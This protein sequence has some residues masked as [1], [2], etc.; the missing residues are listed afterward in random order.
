MAG[1]EVEVR[2]DCGTDVINFARR[3]ERVCRLLLELHVGQNARGRRSPKRLRTDPEPMTLFARTDLHVLVVDAQADRL[4]ATR[5]ALAPAG[6][7]LRPVASVSQAMAA[8]R[9]QAL[10]LAIIDSKVGDVDGLA[11]AAAMRQEPRVQDV[12][13]LMLADAAP[14]AKWLAKAGDA[15]VV[16]VLVRP[17]EPHVLLNKAG[18]I[19]GHRGERRRLRGELAHVER[20][21]RSNEQMVAGLI[22]DLRTP[23]MAINLSAEVVLA[24][25]QEEPV[26]Q[27]ARRIRSSTVRMSRLFDH[28]L[29]LARVGAEVHEIAWKAGNLQEVVAAAVA[30]AQGGRPQTKIE[31]SQDGDDFSGSFDAELVGRAVRNVLGTAIEHAGTAHPVAVRIDGTHRD[32]IWVQVS[33]AAVIPP[34]VQERMFVPGPSTAGREV[35]GFGLGLHH[36]DGFIRAHGG[37]I[38]GRSRAPDGTVFE[39]LLPRDAIA[40][41]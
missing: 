2:C 31:V 29:N 9:E 13:I 6:A 19:L 25:T 35:P 39:L 14:D 11:I 18:L 10:D 15:G 26:Q 32:R 21:L 28:L 22:H 16:D 27:A 3:G 12:P 5:A 24:R 37:S 17:V 4:E 36:I 33:T 38:V 7:V 40:A 30:D 41:T 1:R 34:D 20:L 8:V 23:L